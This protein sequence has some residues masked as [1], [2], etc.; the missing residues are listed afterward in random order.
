MAAMRDTLLDL[1]ALAYEAALEPNLWPQVAEGASRAFEAP[2]VMLGVVD[3]RGN[4]VMDAEPP[5][6]S[7]SLG[8]TPYRTVKTNPGLAFAAVTPPTTVE[9]RER[10]ISDSDLERSQIYQELSGRSMRGMARS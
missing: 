2:R 6:S 7:T 1:V 10:M 8:M 5:G 9:S 4:L 3:R